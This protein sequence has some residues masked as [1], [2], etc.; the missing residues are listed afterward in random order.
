[1]LYICVCVCNLMWLK[2]L[3]MLTLTSLD[4]FRHFLLYPKRLGEVST[5]Q[6]PTLERWMSSQSKFVHRYWRPGDFIFS[7]RSTDELFQ[8]AG[9]KLQ[10]AFFPPYF[11]K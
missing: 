3:L 1:M 5:L 11:E 10:N 7:F 9:W 8:G 4:V 6:K 2:L